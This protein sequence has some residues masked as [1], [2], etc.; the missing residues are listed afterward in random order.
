[1]TTMT[2]STVEPDWEG[3]HERPHPSPTKYVG[4]AML[5]A[6]VTAIEVGL[7]YSGLADNLLIGLLVFFSAVKFLLVTFFFMH[8]RF[9]NRLLRR[10]FF[11]ALLLAGLV[12]TAVLLTLHVFR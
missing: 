2:A 4:I 10:V 5:L 11:L 12:F 8:L 1:M 7:S 9:D 6:L 3:A